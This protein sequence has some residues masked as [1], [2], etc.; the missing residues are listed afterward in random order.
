MC[1]LDFVGL[2]QHGHG[3]GRGV[4]AA[5]RFGRRHALH[6]VHAALVLQAREHA[7][8]R[9]EQDGFFDAAGRRVAA[10]QELDLPAARLRVARVHAQ[11]IGGEQRGF[12]AARAGADF[13]QRVLVVVR[14]LGQE[15]HEDALLEVD[16]LGLELGQLLLDQ[17]TE[18]R[19]IERFAVFGDVLL[20]RAPLLERLDDVAT[21]RCARG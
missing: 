21:A 2:G 6:A 8:A 16:Q 10:G 11:Q 20:D 14:I 15:Q 17:R 4:D 13:E 3:R 1:E 5:L 7:V 19:I 18:L 9:D 12:F